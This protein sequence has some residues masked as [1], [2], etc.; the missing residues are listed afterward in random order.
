MSRSF[1][2]VGLLL[3]VGP[4]SAAAQDHQHRSPYAGHEHR[5]IKALSPSE[6]EELLDGRGMGMALPAELNGYPGPRHVLDLADS[7]DLDSAQRARVQAVFDAMVR[8]ARELGARIVRLERGLDAAFATHT[9][10]AGTLD[11]T[12]EN[13]AHA[14]A[15][16]R[17]VHLRAHLEIYPVLSERQRLAYARLRGYAAR[18]EPGPDGV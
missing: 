2:V 18:P 9:V 1:I 8:D 5:D 14:R 3:L 6:V 15:Q 7:L 11:S 4:G 16:L 10:T 13:L 17:A 12:L